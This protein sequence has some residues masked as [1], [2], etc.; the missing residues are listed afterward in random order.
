MGV[1][2]DGV[3]QGTRIR[4]WGTPGTGTGGAGAHND[5]I[6]NIGEV[7]KIEYGV[8]TNTG[9]AKAHRAPG[10]PQGAFALEQMMDMAADEIGMDRV[11]F[12]KKNDEH[13]IRKVEYDIAKDRIKWNRSLTRN[14]GAETCQGLGIASNLW[15]SAGGGGASALVRITK[16]GQVEVRNGAQDIGTGTRTVMGMVVAEELGLEMN[17]VATRIGN[18]D[19]PQGPASGGSTT[20]GTVTPAARLAAYHAKKE[21]MEIVADRKGWDASELDLKDQEVW[22]IGE[23]ST[24][25]T[26]ESA[27]ALMDD[28]A[29][30]VLKGRPRRNYEGFSDTNAGVQAAHVEVN[31][32]TGAVKVLK[33]VAVADAGKIL[34]PLTSE[35]QVRGGVIQ[36]VSFALFE[37]R[38]MDRQK[39]RMLNDDFENYKILGSMDCPEIDVVL[40]DVYNGKSNTQVMGLGEPPIVATA[41]AVANAVSDAL[42]V[43]MYD[44]PIT[45]K[46]VLEAIAKRDAAKE[47]PAQKK[48]ERL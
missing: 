7:D 29:I 21:L 9:G 26:F 14:G 25:M 41:A 11:E 33:V 46:K 13:P 20:I 30:E 17:Q 32:A 28:D 3:I 18:T 31:Q 4:S 34:N 15:F 27:C 35:S 37:R 19:D 38:I 44:L 5:G 43:R 23:G 24:G 16:D 48:G 12:R 42:G 36:G 45:P 8:R 10:W 2:K 40:L 22:R 47:V 39:G 6:Y 1:N